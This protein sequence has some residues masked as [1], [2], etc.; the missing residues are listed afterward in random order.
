MSWWN[1]Y[2]F[3]PNNGY[4]PGLQPVPDAVRAAAESCRRGRKYFFVY[5]RHSTVF[6]L[7]IFPV[8]PKKAQPFFLY[9][10]VFSM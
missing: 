3:L 10:S 9:T 4:A 1:L 5:S 7:H 6:L 2:D 8:P